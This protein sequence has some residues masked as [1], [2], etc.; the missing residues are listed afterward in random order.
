MLHL[1]L[2]VTLVWLDLLWIFPA[3]S[4]IMWVGYLALTNL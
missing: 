1:D 2:S 4:V 3:A